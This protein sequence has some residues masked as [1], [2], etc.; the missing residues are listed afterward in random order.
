MNSTLLRN[1]FL[2]YFE[3]NKH[4][5]EQSS[6][7]IPAQDP[8]ILF[9]NAGMN[10]FKDLFLGYEKRSYNKATT[11]Q[12]CVRAG[13]K[14][15]D[16][17]QVGFTDRHLT[18]FEM[19][20]NFS[21]GDYFKEEA[22]R[23]AWNF[24]TKEIGIDESK[25]S[26]TVHESD[27]ESLKIWNEQI[28]LPLEKITKMGDED[29]FWQMGDTGPCGPCTEIFFDRGSQWDDK[30]IY[31]AKATRF[32]EVWNLVFM[33]YSQ[34]EDGSRK[35]LDQTGVDTGMGLE[36][37]CMVMSDGETVF[38]TDLFT[39]IFHELEKITNLVYKQCDYKTQ[40]AFNVVAD[41]IRSS[42]MIIA[43][44]G[45]PS[46]DGR[47]YVLRK[48]IRR[49]LLFLKKLTED[50]SVFPK[51]AKIVGQSLETA[52]PDILEKIDI[53]QEILTLETNRFASN[54]QRGHR[55]F[56]Q[57]LA[58]AKS[59]GTNF[60]SGP[61]T[62]KLYDTYGFPLEVSWVLAKENG[63][64]IDIEGFEAEML[65]QK[66]ASGK[67]QKN[68]GFALEIP[69]EIQSE[70][71]GYQTTKTQSKIVWLEFKN[72][73][74]WLVTEKN[75]FFAACGGQVS[76]SGKIIIDGKDVIVNEVH[77]VLC[78]NK[79]VTVLGINTEDL[80]VLP[81]VGKIVALQ[82]D[83]QI[84]ANTAKNHTATHLLQA[85]LRKVLGKNVEQAGS[86]V[87]PDYLRFA[88][89]YTKPM[90]DDEIKMTEKLV[91]QWICGNHEVSQIYTS[92][93][94]AN[95]MGAMALFGEKYN[96]EIVRVICVGDFSAE[97]CGGT[98]VGRSGDIGCFKITSEESLGAGTRSIVAITGPACIDQIQGQNSI[99]KTLC[100]TFATKQDKLTETILKIDADKKNLQREIRALKL[101]DL[102]RMSKEEDSYV[103]PGNN[104][105]LL[106]FE[107]LKLD[108][109]LTKNFVSLFVRN[110]SNRIVVMINADN[111]ESLNFGIWL[112]KDL[113]NR[114]DSKE[115]LSQLKNN[116]E[117][118]VGGKN[119]FLQGIGIV[120]TKDNFLGMMKLLAGV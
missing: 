101:A 76:D 2:K 43:D 97:L 3:N 31:G 53:I 18:F 77:S 47:G 74:V 33:Q 110:K 23:F 16:L 95:E 94:K 6:S 58:E 112:S 73:M 88:F 5:V 49:G 82:V 10:Q 30:E 68:K 98:H 21:F 22:I 111:N 71:I 34:Q 93:E 55:F 65:K 118:K 104:C 25:L 66:E 24:L 105:D 4:K 81:E 87:H 13:G 69:K 51:L 67:D 14:H 113:E 86:L 17:D 109:E 83:E 42:T 102:S 117:Y 75:P 12:K 99:I 92:L 37:L 64:E 60:L 72:N 96:P 108:Q 62:F 56:E 28:G 90:S 91:N 48:I 61:Q 44:G 79:N 78:N 38:D 32:L 116:L 20:G 40:A 50:F 100:S 9:A 114:I 107:N 41:H 27:D 39:P 46:N 70:F 35:L 103:M 57:F 15:N 106:I 85:A 63:L 54:L 36:R 26:V 52:Y 89:T 1:K 11:S 120:K 59:S 115:L 7:L 19:L 119:D 29:N 80:T 84:R 45:K 8:T